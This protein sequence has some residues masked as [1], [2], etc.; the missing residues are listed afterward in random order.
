MEVYLQAVLSQLSTDPVPYSILEAFSEN[1]QKTNRWITEIS[2]MKHQ[3]VFTYIGY[4][5][6]GSIPFPYGPNGRKK[7]NLK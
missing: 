7:K 6:Q 2:I 3:I 4:S 5:D 1:Y